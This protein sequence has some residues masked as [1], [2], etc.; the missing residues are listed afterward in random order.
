MENGGRGEHRPW[1]YGPEVLNIYRRFAILHYELVPYLYSL[2]I[3][4]HRTGTP[5]LR[6]T[7]RNNRQYQLG[8]DLLVVP[9]TGVGGQRVVELP[10]GERWYDFWDDDEILE[11][12]AR[13]QVSMPLDRAPLY[14]RSGAILPLQV[15]DDTWGHGGAA[16]AD[17]LTLLIYPAAHSRIAYYPDPSHKIDI[18]V[19]RQMFS[20]S[21]QIG[22]GQDS[23]VLR[24]KSRPPPRPC[25]RSSVIRS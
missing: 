4:A 13:F 22:A 23:F 9:M 8:P 19:K 14:I 6:Q 10:E 24:I 7:N 20:G 11:G 12:G 17:A 15:E 25:Q 2:G 3:E 1:R 16:S 5:I 18:E 21:V